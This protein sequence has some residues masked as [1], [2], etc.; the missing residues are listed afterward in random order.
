[1]SS[2]HEDVSSIDLQ[3]FRHRVLARVDPLRPETL[4]NVAGDIAALARHPALLAETLRADLSRDGGPVRMHSRQTC[5]LDA[6]GPF[7]VR[8]NLWPVESGAREDNENLSFFAYHDHGFSFLTTNY[9][10][11][12]YRTRTYTYDRTQ[13]R[14]DLGEQVPLTFAGEAMLS[15]GTVLMFLEGRDVHAQFPPPEPTAS[16]NLLLSQDG[17]GVLS[18]QYYFDI[19]SSTICGKPANDLMRRRMALSLADFFRNDATDEL[20][21]TIADEHACPRTRVAA[22][23][24]LER[25]GGGVVTD[26]LA[27]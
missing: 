17:S 24:V 21:R 19:D 14:G 16:L 18:D 25:L 23:R 22:E 27:G 3:E 15:P 6:F 13:V 11:P 4:M 8:I 20:L 9:Y 5:V 26:V 12:G 7:V 1:M 10:G 2:R